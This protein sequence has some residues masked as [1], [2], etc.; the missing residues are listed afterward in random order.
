[1]NNLVIKNIIRIIGFTLIQVL[2]LRGIN[3]GGASFNHIS[4]ILYPIVI[5][6]LPLRTHNIALLF[7][8][9]LIGLTIDVFYDSPGIHA[10]T[11]VATAFLRPYLLDWLTPRGGYNLS[12]ELVPAHYGYAWFFRYAGILL[13]I[14]L[15]MYFS[16]LLFSPVFFIQIL[17]RTV[18]SFLFSML[19][20]V[21][22]VRLFQS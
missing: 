10:A 21:I 7:I 14:H 12:Y 3:P 18:L 22:Y 16:L 13:F 17:V 11:C 15:L 5:V 4:I 6:L 19:F 1:M 8:S 2:V 20:T 9:F